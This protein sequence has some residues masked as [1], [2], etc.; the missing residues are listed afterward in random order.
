MGAGE[1]LGQLGGRG[2]GVFQ[3]GEGVI[4]ARWAGVGVGR[5]IGMLKPQ[6]KSV[7]DSSTVQDFGTIAVKTAA[8]A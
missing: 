4:D 8:A 1:R 7:F 3:M 6:F 2:V 5:M